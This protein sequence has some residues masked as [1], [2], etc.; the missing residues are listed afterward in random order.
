M[1][2]L[3]NHELKIYVEL[4]KLYSVAV[5]LL[6][7][8]KCTDI[9]WLQKNETATKEEIEENLGTNVFGTKKSSLH[10]HRSMFVKGLRVK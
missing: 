4:L 2:H 5:Q 10:V 3:N 9:L 6:K 7:S 8:T 1:S